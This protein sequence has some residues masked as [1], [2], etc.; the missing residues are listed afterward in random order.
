[1]KLRALVL[2]GGLVLGSTTQALAGG[3]FVPGSGAVSTARAGAAVASIL[4]TIGILFAS[5]TIVP[6]RSFTI[7]ES[8]S[9]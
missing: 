1:M 8:G 7:L 6:K 2:G 9:G 3:L 5:R 4:I